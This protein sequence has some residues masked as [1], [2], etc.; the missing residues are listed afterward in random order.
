MRD[1]FVDV[2]NCR[3]ASVVIVEL[4]EIEDHR[5]IVYRKLGAHNAVQVLRRLLEMRAPDDAMR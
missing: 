3:S 5:R 1:N 2:D 4:D